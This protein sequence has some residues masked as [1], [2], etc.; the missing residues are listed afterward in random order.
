MREGSISSSK[1]MTAADKAALIAEFADDMKAERIETLDVRKKTS[2]MEMLVVCTGTS[3]THVSSIADRV[4]EKLRERGVRA[5]RSQTGPT[6]N[7]WCLYDF[8]DV[9]FHVMLEEKRQF[10]D[11]ETLWRT[12]QDDPNLV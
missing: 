11:L 12:I 2:V 10:Y 9:V 3:D 5:L 8:G 7:G 4:E 6:A 1:D